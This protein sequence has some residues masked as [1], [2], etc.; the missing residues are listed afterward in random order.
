MATQK[1]TNKAQD[2]MDAFTD[3][4][5]AFTDELKGEFEDVTQKA[6]KVQKSLAESARDIWLAGL[7]LFSTLEEEGEKLFNSFLEKGKDLEEKGESFEKR[8]K[9]KVD[10]FQTYFAER[11]D[12]VTDEFKKKLNESFPT[13]I[14]EKFQSAL[15]TFGVSSHN[16]VRELNKKVDKLTKAV[17]DLAGKLD[18]SPKATTRKTNSNA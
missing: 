15:E 14:E 5:K 6:E 1:T 2:T 11:T 9:E 12:K 16:E 3:K 4:A 13:V 7:G 18:K 17:A 8:A 10:S